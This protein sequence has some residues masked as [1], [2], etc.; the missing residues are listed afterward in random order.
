MYWYRFHF[1]DTIISHEPLSN[2]K[3]EQMI[4]SAHPNLKNNLGKGYS[5]QIFNG[6]KIFDSKVPLKF[7]QSLVIVLL[8]Y[9]NTI[10]GAFP[11]LPGPLFSNSGLVGDTQIE[12]SY[13]YRSCRNTTSQR[14]IHIWSDLRGLFHSS[15]SYK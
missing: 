6:V 8:K 11:S 15:S 2:I 3:T 13:L 5:G 1:C 14:H 9:R 7:S 4:M 12:Y 10:E